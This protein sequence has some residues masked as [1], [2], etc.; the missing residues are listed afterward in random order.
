MTFDF[1]RIAIINR[2]EPAMRLIHAVRELNHERGLHLQTI[3]LYTE[4]DAVAMFVR[5]A[6]ESFSLGPATF[7]DPA[8][9]QRKSSYLDYTRLKEAL[10]KTQADAAWVGWG[11]VAEHPQFA[12][13]CDALAVTFI[14]PKGAVMRQLGDKIQAKRL[15]ENAN[16]PVAAWSGGPVETLAEA[17]KA[18]A[19]IGYPLLVKASAGGGGRGIRKVKSQRELA[20]A[21]ESA[22][23]ESLKSFG[24][25]TVFLEKL[26]ENARHVEVQIVA[27]HHG[28]TWAVGV[29]DCTIQRRN[30]KVVEEAPSP[31]LDAEQD[32]ELRLAAKRLAQTAGYTNAGTVECLYAPAER[33]FYFMEMN[34]RLQVEH[35]VTEMTTGLDLV[36]LQLHIA[37]GGRLEGEPPQTLG[38]AIEVRLNAEDPDNSFAPAPGRV[39][40]FELPTGPGLRVD[41]GVRQGDEVPADFDSMIAKLIAWGRTRAE[42]MG[43]L[44]RAL[45][46][47]GVVIRGGSSN[48]AFLLE[49]LSHPEVTEARY[50]IGW[51]DRLTEQGPGPR[52]LADVALIQA[53]I[54]V[55]EQELAV[56]LTQ[57]FA[58]AS[59]G[60][61]TVRDDVGHEVELRYGGQTYQLAVR[62]IAAQRYRVVVEGRVIEVHLERQGLF[63]GWLDC[64]GTRYRVLSVV[65][66]P[67][68]FVEVDGMPHRIS[69]DEGGVVRAPAPAVTLSIIARPGAM[70]SRGD[71]LV[72]LEAMKMEMAVPAPC[73]GRIRQVTVLPNQQV[74]AGDPLVLLEPQGDV[75]SQDSTPRVVF[76]MPSAHSE[77]LAPRERCRHL[78]TDMRRLVMGYDLDDQE[79][80]QILKRRGEIC[81]LLPGADP[82]LWEHENRV[83]TLFA[84]MLAL[85]RKEPNGDEICAE[86]HLRSYLRSIDTGMERLP[87]SFKDVLKRALSHYGVEGLER[88]PKLEQALL[89]VHKAQLRIELLVQ[90]V[91][92]LLERRLQDT[93]ELHT[94]ATEDFRLL[95]DRLIDKTQGLYPPLNDLARELRYRFFDR[96]FF[97]N[98]RREIYKEVNRQLAQL[99]DHPDGEQRDA[100]IQWLAACP[101]PIIGL[102]AT[103][104]AGERGQAARAIALEVMVRRLYS[105]CSVK[106]IAAES[107]A[108]TTT[109]SAN[110]ERDRD[111]QCQKLM[112]FDG[113]LDALEEVL[114]LANAQLAKG[115]PEV[116]DLFLAA[117]TGPDPV[118]L[119][120]RISA[121]LA[122]TR[123]PGLRSLTVGVATPSELKNAVY[124]TFE[125]AEKDQLKEREV[126]R[127]IHPMLAARLE[128]WR[129]RN[130]KTVQLRVE[131][132]IYLF[133]AVARDNPKDERLF[134]FVEVRDTS[135]VRDSEGRLLQLPSLEWRYMEALAGIRDFQSRRSPR[136]RL[137]W[138]RVML[139]VRP[140]VDFAPDDVQRIAQRLTPPA[141]GLGLEKVVAHLLLKNPESGEIEE[142]VLHASNR[143]GTGL[144]I[145]LQDLSAEPIRPL[146]AYT[147]RVVTMRRFGLVYPYEVIRMLTP[148]SESVHTEFPSG[149][150]VEYDLDEQ[151]QLVPVE[152]T[153]GN[154]HANVVVG[155]IT[156]F[157]AKIPEGMQRMI[158]LGDASREM[159]A[160]AEPECRRIIGALNLADEL[161][162]PLEW[163]PVSSGA[164]IAWDVGTEGL[165]WV[166][167]VVRRLVEFTQAGGE[168]NVIIAGVNVGGQSYWNAEATMLMHTR[169]ILVMTPNASMVLTGKKALDYS[170]GVS[171][172]DNAGIGGFERIMGPNG[173]AQYAAR[174][175]AEACHI[176]FKHYDYTY[177]VPGEHFPRLAPTKDPIDRDILSAPHVQVEGCDFQTIGEVFS[178]KTN[179]GRKKP[180]D[181]RSVMTAVVD[182]GEEPLERWAMMRNAETAVVWDVHLAGQPIS[183]IGIESRLLSRA[184]FVPWD[185][186]ETWTGGTLFPRSS[187]KVAR[188][189]NAA[190]NNRP[191]VVLANLSG[192]DGSPE[193]MRWLQLEYGAEIGRAVVNFEG[194]I[195]FVVISRY[196]GGAYVVFSCTLNDN[197]EAAALEGSF[198]SVIGGAPAA[199][200]VF[201]KEVKAR[202]MADPRVEAALKAS[203]GAVGRD[204]PRL[205][206][207]F[208]E[209]YNQVYA[210]KQGEVAEGFDAVH[211]VERAQKVGSLHHIIPPAQLR[212]Y[213][214]DAVERGIARTLKQKEGKV[215]NISAVS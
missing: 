103:A 72:I 56:E 214:A 162:I 120:A 61:P 148:E 167:R 4:P 93:D 49:L 196:H 24:D 102:L 145:L 121:A 129:L 126:L 114:K 182:A 105:V 159:G 94:L 45:I 66:G 59:R 101:Q 2:G 107:I 197:L 81:K 187:K 9:G 202:T 73:A 208:D 110:F 211:C 191:V 147:Q 99:L 84:D 29:R 188:A 97:E 206:A 184:G 210:E 205:R 166:A 98:T 106:D 131:D 181:I 108:D 123:W 146:T 212:A 67:R 40:L 25:D 111:G 119:A 47:S 117:S 68:H 78:M 116:I 144:R 18:A 180:F 28:S 57:F 37:A 70:V 124:V 189:I 51:L 115:K 112:T 113:H 186:P 62:R 139:F 79:A 160:L 36:K 151:Q 213:L 7:V 201:P 86:E 175:I 158:I 46:E 89:Y 31:V 132:D 118:Q 171:A 20:T 43:R 195:T 133:H 209:T 58:G 96:P 165:D 5:E 192:F 174:D 50:D 193:S 179:P 19:K 64:A 22:R 153:P 63:R 82:E 53:A 32:A 204:K 17:T 170:G 75:E 183:L 52:P 150:F 104:F 12:D 130:F 190:S 95:L 173:L 177:L 127:G 137:H 194:P 8:D 34:T 10:I 16:V 1:R 178:L 176:L 44:R 35:P 164:K 69:R 27:D 33:L 172:E 14:G 200:V 65:D 149:E 30:Q 136:K 100:Q 155:L 60:R 71:P 142:K 41:T 76:R 42:A 161:N 55:Y 203:Q 48:K 85:F 15:A 91:F 169:G 83:L 138:N 199:A 185:G 122:N 21:F 125:P 6:D 152:R 23:S 215:P 88:T 74:G 135:A 26:V 109:L 143:A 168:V 141:K 154:N 3:A 38:H 140:P 54:D 39:D 198:A 77:P 92:S 207:T 13:L 163:F 80:R 90:Q 157:T 134:A 87:D 156:N 11:F 128:L